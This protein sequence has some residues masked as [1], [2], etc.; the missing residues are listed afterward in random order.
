M[1]K[2]S[3]KSILRFIEKYNL[4]IDLQGDDDWGQPGNPNIS[5]ATNPAVT[6]R[7][8]GTEKLFY[9]KS[10]KLTDETGSEF[11]QASG[12]IAYP[13]VTTERPWVE[14][15]FFMHRGSSADIID[16]YHIDP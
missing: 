9:I 7:A 11:S 2:R 12:T 3:N 1:E 13:M 16:V 14:N 4:D 6:Y 10:S 15:L 8:F 5:S